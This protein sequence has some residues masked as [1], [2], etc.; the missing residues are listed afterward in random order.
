MTSIAWASTT[1]KRLKRPQKRGDVD[2]LVVGA[3]EHVHV[4]GN[5]KSVEV[6]A[7]DV[8]CQDVHGS[9]STIAGDVSCGTVRGSISTVSGDINH[10]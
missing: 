6:K 9:V 8:S 2:S 5:V 3:C 10:R 1:T 7:G 4:T